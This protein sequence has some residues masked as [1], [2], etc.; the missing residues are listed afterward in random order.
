M[1]IPPRPKNPRKSRRKPRPPRKPRRHRRKSDPQRVWAR[2]KQLLE[3]QRAQV[4]AKVTPE[5]GVFERDLNRGLQEAEFV[6]RVVGFT[7]VNVG[8]E[9]FFLCQQAQR[10]GELDLAAGS[11]RGALEAVERLR[12]QHVS[13]CDAKV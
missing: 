7:L 3:L 4:F 5:V 10:V 9:P 11:R 13:A 1:A 6:A 8:P 12:R 2:A